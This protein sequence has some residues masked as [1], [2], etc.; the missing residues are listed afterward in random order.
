MTTLA[1]DPLVLAMLSAAVGPVVETDCTIRF[2]VTVTDC[3]VVDA[4]QDGVEVN[5][6]VNGAAFVTLPLAGD[7]AEIVQPVGAA[8]A[9]IVTLADPVRLD[10][11][12][13]QETAWLA[14]TETVKDAG[15]QTI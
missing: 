13:E 8:I 15:V 14:I 3:A 1:A 2:E 12:S 6:K 7:G 5:E 9:G 4:E 10:A 11:L